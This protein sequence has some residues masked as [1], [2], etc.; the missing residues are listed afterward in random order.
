M[1]N[2][3]TF[4]EER[5]KIA[6]RIDDVLGE[7]PEVTCVY[8]LGSVASGHVDERS[9]VDITFVCRSDILP[10]STRQK[11]LSQIGSELQFNSASGHNPIWDAFDDGVVDGIPVQLHYQTAPSISEV[12][13]EVI[14]NGAITTEKVPFR[15]YTVAAML[16][17]AWLLRD[18]DGVFKGWLEQTRVYPQ[19]LKQNI[20]RYFVFILRENTEELVSNAERRHG[21]ANNIFFLFL[22]SDALKR[23]LYALND[24]YDAADRREEITILP[25]LRYVPRDFIPRLTYV[26]EGP[27]DASGTLER[28]KLFEQLATEVLKM[29]E[30]QMS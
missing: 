21:P 13:D 27:F 7:H 24:M 17:R 18:K 20:L 4:L 1:S 3:D 2:K 16:Q 14:N 19:R 8:V 12:L 25:T 5:R 6:R 30:A 10:L 11:I 29:A 28:A 23:V 22:A 15:P 26:L 9:D